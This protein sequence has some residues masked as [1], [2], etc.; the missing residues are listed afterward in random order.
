MCNVS[1]DKFE[2]YWLLLYVLSDFN[3][4]WC[5]TLILSHYPFISEIIICYLMSYCRHQSRGSVEAVPLMTRIRVVKF[6]WLSHLTQTVQGRRRIWHVTL[7][8]QVA[9]IITIGS[10]LDIRVS[11]VPHM[12]FISYLHVIYIFC[13]LF[14]LCTKIWPCPLG[15]LWF[16]IISMLG[17]AVGL[18]A[19][20]RAYLSGAWWVVSRVFVEF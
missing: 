10:R 5:I 13:I 7:L 1:S 3:V 20:G 14:D 12:H 17:Y 8:A 15:L 4:C 9:T 16:V 11:L 18:D 6:C 19:S 2:V